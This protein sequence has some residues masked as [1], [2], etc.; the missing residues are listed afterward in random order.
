MGERMGRRMKAQITL[1]YAHLFPELGEEG[2]KDACRCGQPDLYMT[3]V[4]WNALLPS[5][6]DNCCIYDP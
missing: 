2:N 1:F 4:W 5:R 6:H 3:F